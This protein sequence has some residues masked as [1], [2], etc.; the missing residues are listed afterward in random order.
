MQSKTQQMMMRKTILATITFLNL[1]VCLQSKS[2]L[3]WSKA[4]VQMGV[5][6]P[7]PS[8]RAF[9]ILPWGLA[10]S[11]FLGIWEASGC[12][13]WVLETKDWSLQSWDSWYGNRISPLWFHR[14]H[15]LIYLCIAWKHCSENSMEG[16]F[17]ND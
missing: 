9:L 5:L 1:V 11:N 15:E 3:K 14:N 8:P 6:V 12:H 4:Y 7:I 13:R 2:Q 16:I 17:S 10:Y